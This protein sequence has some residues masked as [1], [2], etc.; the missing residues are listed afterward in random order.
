LTFFVGWD[1][2]GSNPTFTFMLNNKSVNVS[3]PGGVVTIAGLN[4]LWAETLGDDRICVA[5]LDGPVDQAHPSLVAANLTRL[6]TLASGIDDQGPASQHGTHVTSIIFGQH[7]SPIKGIAPHC[8]GLIVPIFKD[9]ADGSIAPCSQLDLARAI[10]QNCSR[11]AQPLAAW[12]AR[13]AQHI[14]EP[15]WAAFFWASV[16]RL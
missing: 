1:S 13:L 11:L 5:V 4:E 12:Q 16:A 14:P 15:D 9:G 2:R 3:R 7:D 6:E 8:R 10:T